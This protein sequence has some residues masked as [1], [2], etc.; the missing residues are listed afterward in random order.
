MATGI[1]S[2]AADLL[3]LRAAA[4]LLFGINL[5]AYVALVLLT[6]VRLV[7]FRERVAADFRR[8]ARAPGFLT[9]V[10]GTCILGTQFIVL[11]PAPAIAAGLWVV[12]GV[13]WVGLIYGLFT[14]FTIQAEKPP[15]DEGMNGTWMLIVVATQAVSVLGTLLAPHVGNG[16]EVVLSLSLGLF[17]L[18]GMF[19]LLLFSLILYRFLFFPFDPEGLTPPYWI[20]MGAVAIT[21]LAGSLLILH[22]DEWVFLREVLPFLKGFT[23][24]FWATATWWIPLL[25]VLGAWRHLSRRVPLRYNVQ[26]W[27]MVFPLGMYA[28][29]TLRLTEAVGWSFLL[30]LPRVIGYIALLAWTLTFIGLL[31]HLLHIAREEP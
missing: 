10:A 13:L 6:L 28:V 5:V 20:N 11:A 16:H 9:V 4:W 25:L 14:V 21:T 18:G 22:S 3:G 12:G 1:V 29:A 15:L 24:L 27:S 30:P 7:R 17:L 19:Y 26:Y 23:L 8:H 31:R 2:T